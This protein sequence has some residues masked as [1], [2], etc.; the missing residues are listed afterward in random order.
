MALPCEGGKRC[1]Q[2]LIWRE[3]NGLLKGVL[4][5]FFLFRRLPLL[6][7]RMLGRRLRLCL[8]DFIAS[9]QTFD[10]SEEKTLS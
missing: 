9:T 5:L 7:Q 3:S 6:G 4:Q 10:S 1:G 2:N 8:T